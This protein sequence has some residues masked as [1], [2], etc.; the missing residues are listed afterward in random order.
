[1]TGVTETDGK[2]TNASYIGLSDVTVKTTSFANENLAKEFMKYFCSNP[3][4]QFSS[5]SARLLSGT[6]SVYRDLEKVLSE[7]AVV[8][9]PSRFLIL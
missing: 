1:M 8:L 7:I 9:P 3:Q 6:T 4:C 5:A 2:L